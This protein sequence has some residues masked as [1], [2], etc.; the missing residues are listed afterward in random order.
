VTAL[1]VYATNSSGTEQAAR[2]ARDV[3]VDAG[4]TVNLKRAYHADPEEMGNYDLVVLG[5]NTWDNWVEG[6]RLEGQLQ[7]H[8]RA[9]IERIPSGSLAGRRIAVFGLGDSSY[10]RIC[11]AADLLEELVAKLGAVKVGDTLR[12]DGFFF[13]PER[14]RKRVAD[15][16]RSLARAG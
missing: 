6:K 2:I 4:H 13:N 3:L 5:S 16:T 15:W 14:N 11:G 10:N 7:E 1:I 8:M 12:V 9:F